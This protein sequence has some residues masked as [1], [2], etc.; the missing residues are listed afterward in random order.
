MGTQMTC[1]VRSL[2]ISKD[3]QCLAATTSEIQLFP[4]AGTTRFL[5]PVRS[6]KA[7][8]GNGMPPY[9][10]E[11]M[12]SHGIELKSWQDPRRMAWQHQSGGINQQ[13][14][15]TPATYTGFRK[16]CIVIWHDTLQMDSAGKTLLRRFQDRD[17]VSYL[18]PGR[19]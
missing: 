17:G 1:R 16:F 10:L 5:H 14:L 19:Q 13:Q 2:C 6:A 12:R 15:T 9:P 7:L 4:V 11:A 3:L 18:V 8:E